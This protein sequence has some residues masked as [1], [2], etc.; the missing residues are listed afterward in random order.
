MGRDAARLDAVGQRVRAG[1]EVA[2]EGRGREVQLVKWHLVYRWSGGARR[3]AT[4]RPERFSV[5][6]MGRRCQAGAKGQ[7]VEG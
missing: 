2:R 1:D 5:Y 3:A 7:D 4:F 6:V